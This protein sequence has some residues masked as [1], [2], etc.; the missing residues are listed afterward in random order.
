MRSAPSSSRASTNPLTRKLRLSWLVMRARGGVLLTVPS[1]PEPD[2]IERPPFKVLLRSGKGF[3][4]E[5]GLIT[6]IW[7]CKGCRPTALKAACLAIAEEAEASE[8]KRHHRPRRGFRALGWRVT[9]PTRCARP[10]AD[11]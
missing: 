1:A 3:I 9:C 2:A 7:R 10:D 6:S 11:A 5:R 8:A 4:I